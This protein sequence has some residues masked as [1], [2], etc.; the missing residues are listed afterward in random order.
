M[1]N[2][3]IVALDIN[4]TIIEGDT[5]SKNSNVTPIKQLTDPAANLIRQ[6]ENKA[7]IVLYTFGNEYPLAVEVINKITQ[8]SVDWHYYFIV[9]D[10]TD[11]EKVWALPM[12][13]TM[14]NNTFLRVTGQ[15]NPTLTEKA[16][17]L[18]TTETLTDR[19]T[20]LFFP[21]LNAFGDFVD[22]KLETGGLVLRAAYDPN[23]RDRTIKF[24]KRGGFR[25]KLLCS[26]TRRIIAFDDNPDDWQIRDARKSPPS[27][28]LVV[29]PWMSEA[30]GIPLTEVNKLKTHKKYKHDTPD[31]KITED[32][33]KLL[34]TW[35]G[36]LNKSR[37]IQ[38]GETDMSS[39]FRISNMMD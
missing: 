3:P 29:S 13:E 21:T 5:A 9:R 27:A 26:N 12:P 16:Y 33:V 24:N 1:Q 7:K 19:T 2:Y 14:E 22:S 32:H 15:T 8:N 6:I 31:L 30:L 11:P 20:P 28:N 4:G 18:M 36:K 25:A 17:D 39:L 38:V 23:P 10:V 34:N 35:G 37:T